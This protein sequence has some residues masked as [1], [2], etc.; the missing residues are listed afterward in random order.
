MFQSLANAA[1]LKS[2][3]LASPLI[4]S[5]SHTL[6]HRLASL[7]HGAIHIIPACYPASLAAPP[8]GAREQGRYRKRRSTVQ[9][10][11]RHR[12][13]LGLVIA[14]SF[15]ECTSDSEQR[16]REQ[17]KKDGSGLLSLSHPDKPFSLASC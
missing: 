15:S 4:L 3:S 12:A 6:A 5:Y 16:S 2:I 1:H 17:A 14:L 10:D 11:P 8:D 7:A 9:R 13:L